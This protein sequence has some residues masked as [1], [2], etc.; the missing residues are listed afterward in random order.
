M[1]LSF[2]RASSFCAS[3]CFRFYSQRELLFWELF[4]YLSLSI[5][6]TFNLEQSSKEFVF[7]L[8]FPTFD[9][10][11]TLVECLLCL[12]YYLF[13]KTIYNRLKT[14]FK[15]WRNGLV[16]KSSCCFWR[17]PG[18][19]SQH[20]HG[21]SQPSLTT[22]TGVFM[23]SSHPWGHQTHTVCIYACR[24]NT[25]KKMSKSNNR[26]IKYILRSYRNVDIV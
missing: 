11:D 20:P 4:E 12:L 7:M 3:T 22:L 5:L 17:G 15:A 6:V 24:Q 16:V 14:H 10:A 23:G 9:F 2:S 1:W 8:S 21:G 25:L 18:F 26:Y 13:L 19:N